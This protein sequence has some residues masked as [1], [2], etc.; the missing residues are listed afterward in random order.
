MWARGIPGSTLFAVSRVPGSP[1]PRPRPL[2]VPLSG[3]APGP[4]QLDG[5]TVRYVQRVHRLGLGDRLSFFDPILGVEA[6]AEIVRSG[7]GSIDCE[8][9]AVHPS[10]YRAYPISLLQALAKG[11]KPDATIAEATAL[12]VERIVLLESERAVVRLDEERGVSRRARWQRIAVEA[13]RQCGR[14]KTPLLQGPLPLM[15]VLPQVL[16]P[17]RLLLAAGGAPL[18][19]RLSDWQP[20]QAVALLVGPEGGLSAQE[21][22]RALQLGFVAASLGPTTLRSELAG[23]AAL[24]A[25]VAFAALRGIG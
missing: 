20:N 21:I 4:R 19:E 9:D 11:S 12:G 8:I 16:E 24:G 25:L 15:D 17:R 10:G 7:A 3:L 22:E 14:G 6:E 18:L 13:A 23:V 5:A 2:R 1:A